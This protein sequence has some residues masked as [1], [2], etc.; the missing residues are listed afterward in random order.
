MKRKRDTDIWSI[1]EIETAAIAQML[2]DLLFLQD[3]EETTELF[4]RKTI[5][6]KIKRAFKKGKSF[7]VKS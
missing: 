6:T 3:G 2:R 1:D 5:R 4:P 7:S